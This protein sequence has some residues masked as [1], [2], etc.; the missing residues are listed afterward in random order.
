M[1]SCDTIPPQSIAINCEGL[2]ECS[3]GLHTL[4]SSKAQR[5]SIDAAESRDSVYSNGGM[6]SGSSR[7]APVFLGLYRIH[8]LYYIVVYL[9]VVV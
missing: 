2:E 9:V 6:F 5:N 7:Y 8:N 1:S 3:A 4:L